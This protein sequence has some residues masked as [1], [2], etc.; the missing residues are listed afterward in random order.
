M[1]VIIRSHE[2]SAGIMPEDQNPL[3]R[4]DALFD[5]GIDLERNYFLV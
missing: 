2:S 3:I 4:F 5:Q 1:P